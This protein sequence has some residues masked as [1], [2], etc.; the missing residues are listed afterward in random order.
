MGVV[1]RLARRRLLD[2]PAPPAPAP[3]W[4][5]GLP[6]RT[7]ARRVLGDLAERRILDRSAALSYYFLFALFPAL[8]FLTALMG[9]LPVP[10]LVERLMDYLAQVLPGEAASLVRRTV[11]ESLSV[12]RRSLLSAGAIAAL[13][14]AS[15]GMTSVISALNGALDVSDARPWW[16]RRLIAIGLTLLFS[17][18][19]LGA[20]LLLASGGQMGRA[21]AAEVGLG[22]VF[23]VAWTILRWPVAVAAVLVGIALV[24]KLAPAAR[25]PWR[26]VT[27][28]SLVALAGWLLAS[29]GL[30]FAVAALGR[31]NPVYGP[32]GGIILLMLWLYLTSLMLLVGAEV[33]G[34]IARAE[35]EA[36]TPPR[37]ARRR[38]A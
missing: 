31:T 23:A 38:A 2:P 21:V 8:L 26:W 7:L 15:S 32:I 35:A 16:W 4:L 18:F 12:A 30:R 29:L 13:W 28:G 22:S 24:F 20:L 37:A 10:R 17:L 19:T 9:F 33:D 36:T 14:G 27:P 34:A 3:R 1:L 25:P 5:G 6:A 11:G